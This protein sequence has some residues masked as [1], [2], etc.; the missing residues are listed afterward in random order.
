MTDFADLAALTIHDVKNRLAI[1]A[2][3]AEARDD[4]ETLHGVLAAA[5][6]LTRLLACY[7]AER[8][9]LGIEVDAHVPTDL[10]AELAGEIRRQTGLLIEIEGNAAPTLWFYDENLIRLVLLNALYNALRYARSKIVIAAR[11]CST[12]LEFTVHDDGPG[13]PAEMLA[14]ETTIQ[15]LGREGTGLG[16]YLAKHVATLHNNAGQSG[17]IELG[18]DH[19]A[20]FRLRLP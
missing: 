13:F 12:H 3:R 14:Q 10:L 2:G 15:P 18:N 8:G 20:L 6:A 11:L 19:G 16:L 4:A 17:C 5:N 7:K 9:H 1:L